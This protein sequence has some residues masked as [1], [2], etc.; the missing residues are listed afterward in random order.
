M[1]FAIT[2]HRVNWAGQSFIKTPEQSVMERS[3]RRKREPWK[4]DSQRVE[5][6]EERTDHSNS[7]D[8]VNGMVLNTYHVFETIPFTPSQTLL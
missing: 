5:A 8:V 6:A 4:N 2:N 1:N 7:Q 3:L